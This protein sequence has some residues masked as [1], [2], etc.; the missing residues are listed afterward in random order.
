MSGGERRGRG[1][2]A[3]NVGGVVEVGGGRG[4]GRLHGVGGGAG[5]SG[6]GEDGDAGGARM[7]VVEGAAA[8]SEAPG[9]SDVGRP[10]LPM[11]GKMQAG[12]PESR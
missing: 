10:A 7:P 12:T 8:K 2:R 3:A 6:V 4:R 11:S 1:C 5:P 9:A